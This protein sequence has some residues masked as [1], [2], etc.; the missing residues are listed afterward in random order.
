MLRHTLGSAIKLDRVRTSSDVQSANWSK[1]GCAVI[2]NIT[3]TGYLSTIDI[4][5]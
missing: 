3:E 4:Q 1:G 5:S 2:E